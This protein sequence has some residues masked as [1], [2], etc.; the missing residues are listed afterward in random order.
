MAGKTDHAAQASTGD[1]LFAK[2]GAFLTANRLSPDPA[3]Y[4]FAHAVLANADGLLAR[5][6][7]EITDGGVRLTAQDIVRLGGQAKTG[8]PIA[9]AAGADNDDDDRMVADPAT[10]QAMIERV[11]MQ[12]AGFDDTITIAHAEANNFG[13]DLAHLLLVDSGNGNNIFFYR[14]L[15]AFRH[16]IIHRMGKADI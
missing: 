4:S 7:A 3:H 1:R 2:I 8:A 6:V 12:I 13:R 10:H 5:R 16:G 15:N 11:L 14:D 9:A